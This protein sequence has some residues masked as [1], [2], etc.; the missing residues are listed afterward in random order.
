[1]A[2]YEAFMV[3]F[4]KPDHSLEGCSTHERLFSRLKQLL[5][6]RKLARILVVGS[7]VLCYVT[8]R[9]FLATDQLVRIYRKVSLKGG[10]GCRVF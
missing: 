2:L 6:S 5:S 9:S 1:M 10:S 4:P 8:M 7:A 3:P